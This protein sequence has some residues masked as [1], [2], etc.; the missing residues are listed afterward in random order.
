MH[1][2]KV[3]VYFHSHSLW[4]LYSETLSL[5]FPSFIIIVCL[6]INQFTCYYKCIILHITSCENE[7][8]QLQYLI[9]NAE[10][11]SCKLKKKKKKKEKKKLI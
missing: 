4:R 1:V 8:K 11:S 6:K 5:T 9:S 3:I 10:I 7:L 2:V